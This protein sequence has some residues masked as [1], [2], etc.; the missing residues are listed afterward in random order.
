MIQ[1]AWGHRKGS[2]LKASVGLDENVLRLSAGMC[3]SV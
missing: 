3:Q 2:T 1:L